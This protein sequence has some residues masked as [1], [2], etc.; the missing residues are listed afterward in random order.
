MNS[1]DKIEKCYTYLLVTQQLRRFSVNDVLQIRN[2]QF[3]LY[4]NC[5]SGTRIY[6]DYIYNSYFVEVVLSEF[7]FWL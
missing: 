2:Y 6:R 5:L 7:T 3:A 1:I 4:A